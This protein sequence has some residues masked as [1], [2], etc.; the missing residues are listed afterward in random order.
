M[1]ALWLYRFLFW[2]TIHFSIHEKA[3]L[4][5]D[6]GFETWRCEDVSCA[7]TVVVGDCPTAVI[8]VVGDGPST[9]IVVVGDGPPTVIVVG[10]C[11]KQRTHT[12]HT[13]TDIDTPL[14]LLVL[15]PPPLH[16]LVCWCLRQERGRILGQN[17][18]L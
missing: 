15:V 5:G 16:F 10:V 17:Y 9:V 6:G 1:H 18:T 8:I 14:L 11:D 2:K 7:T 13:Q 3:N 4:P 12:V